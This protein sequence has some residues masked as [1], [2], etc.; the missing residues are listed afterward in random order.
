ML[1]GRLLFDQGIY[2]GSLAGF[3]SSLF[4]NLPTSYSFGFMMTTDLS[5]YTCLP[6]TATTSTSTTYTTYTAYLTAFT[7]A[8]TA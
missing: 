1:V 4:S 5:S 2:A 7:S 6:S 8:L 3:T